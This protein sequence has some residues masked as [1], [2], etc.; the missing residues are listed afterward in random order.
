MLPK[1]FQIPWRHRE[2]NGHKVL[3]GRLVVAA[4]VGAAIMRALYGFLL[5]FLAFAI[6]EE[7]LAGSVLFV[8][9]SEAGQLALVGIALVLGTFIATAIGSGLTIKQPVRLQAIGAG[10]VAVLALWATVRVTLPAIVLYCV[11]AAVASGL[12]KLAVDASIQERIT[13]TVRASAFAH[14]ETLLMLAWVAGAALGLIPFGDIRVGLGVAALAL[15]A[16]ATR[17]TVLARRMRADRLTGKVNGGGIPAPAP[18]RAEAGGPAPTQ[19]NIHEYPGG[20]DIPPGYHVFQ[21][22]TEDREGVSDPRS[23]P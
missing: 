21:P 1:L 13:E 20:L 6:K 9:V 5:V 7:G 23:G 22:T 4:L 19:T 8:S 2:E 14:A 12:A 3:S 18:A 17:A 15:V 16:A 11:A 10:L